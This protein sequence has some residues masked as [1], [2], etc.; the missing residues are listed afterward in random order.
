MSNRHIALR[1]IF[2][3]TLLFMTAC[4]S[5][6]A[7]LTSPAADSASATGK[8]ECQPDF[9][10]TLNPTSATIT[11]G[12]SVKI[13]ANFTSICGLTGGIYF[14]ISN[15]SPS[16]QGGDG[17]TI[18]E[19]RYDVRF[20]NSKAVGYITLGA[21]QYTLKTTWTVT[22]TGKSI[23]GGCCYGLTHSATFLLKVQ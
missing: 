14:G 10:M 23:G 7:A 9:T 18:Y 22:I 15:V 21:T 12:Q 19:P 8:V 20:V 11:T 6:G 16:P 4:Q 5:N 2:A 3:V 17:F 13:A 1:S